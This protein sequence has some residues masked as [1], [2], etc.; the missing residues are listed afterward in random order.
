MPFSRRLPS[1]RR[2]ETVLTILTRIFP[3]AHDKAQESL[4]ANVMLYLDPRVPGTALR[5][6][7]F[8]H[9]FLKKQSRESCFALIE[10]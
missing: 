2:P 9:S 7:H 3:I 10:S 8:G 4:Q 6:H 1:V 5:A